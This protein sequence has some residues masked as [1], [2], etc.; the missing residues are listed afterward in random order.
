MAILDCFR[1][2]D[3]A[4][5]HIMI[6][7]GCC[8]KKITKKLSPANSVSLLNLMELNDEKF[9]YIMKKIELI[10]NIKSDGYIDD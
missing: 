5:A 2:T 4:E 8:N 9:N 1:P 6:K 10:K 3:Q 7:V